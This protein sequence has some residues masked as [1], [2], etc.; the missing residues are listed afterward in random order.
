MKEICV[1]NCEEC[2]FMKSKDKLYC[3][4]SNNL[5]IEDPKDP[6]KWCPIK[7]GVKIKLGT[8]YSKKYKGEQNKQIG[9]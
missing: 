6:P 4:I 3:S 1:K 5:M 2:P 9:V 8:E 7:D